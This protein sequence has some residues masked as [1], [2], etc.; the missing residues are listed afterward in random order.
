MDRG[1]EPT[2]ELATRVPFHDRRPNGVDEGE[3][4]AAHVESGGPVE[5]DGLDAIAL[6]HA[7][8][9]VED[10]RDRGPLGG[11]VV[12]AEPDQQLPGDLGAFD[13][14]AH[15]VPGD[16]RQAVVMQ[17]RGVPEDPTIKG[18][19]LP[20]RDRGAPEIGPDRMGQ[21]EVRERAMDPPPGRHRDVI[22]RD[23]D[24][25]DPGRDGRIGAHGAIVTSGAPG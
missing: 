16:P 6:G 21:Q 14:E 5:Q 19:G 10:D 18:P 15:R 3:A 9:H 23:V 17:E 22:L 7:R 4:V 12:Q 1:Q 13:L 8:L 25:G 2:I 24:A 11:V 20:R